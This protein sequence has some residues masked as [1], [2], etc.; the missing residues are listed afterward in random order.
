MNLFYPL[1]YLLLPFLL[2]IPLPFPCWWRPKTQG[3][4][5]QTIR[6]LEF[7]SLSKVLLII[8]MMTISRCCCASR[9]LVRPHVLQLLT[10]QREDNFAESYA[11]CR[12]RTLQCTREEGTRS[13]PEKLMTTAHTIRC[14]AQGTSAPMLHI[15]SFRIVENGHKKPR[16]GRRRPQT[17]TRNNDGPSI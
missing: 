14:V 2:S 9:R 13:V 4:F 5:E 12:H 1:S 17:R 15:R 6:N 8:I 10:L 16:R 3:N 11:P 7:C